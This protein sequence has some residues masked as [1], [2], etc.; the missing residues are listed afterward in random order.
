[1]NYNEKE[2]MLRLSDEIL[3]KYLK[4][5]RAVSVE[6]PKLCGKTWT[7]SKYAKSCIFL[8]E[9][10]TY[11]RA[12]LNLE[13]VLNEKKPELIDEWTKIPKIWDAVR[14]KCDSSSNTGNYILTCST[15][16]SEQRKKEVFHSG[17]GR[18][19]KLKM[20]PMSLYESGEHLLLLLLI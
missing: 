10:A 17:A 19:G 9:D 5:F 12:S 18:I 11:E 14:R 3:E 7:S 2:Y 13:M 20:Y 4:V 16:L 6:G 15:E 8:D 1:M